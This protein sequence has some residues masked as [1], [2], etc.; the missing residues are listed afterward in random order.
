MQENIRELEKTVNNSKVNP[1]WLKKVF[2]I[3]NLTNSGER[4]ETKTWR[5][6]E[7]WQ[8]TG[9]ES[10]TEKEK[11]D[12]KHKP[13]PSMAL[14]KS[15]RLFFFSSHTTLRERERERELLNEDVWR[16][17]MRSSS[18]STATRTRQLS[19]IR[20]SDADVLTRVLSFW[21]VSYEDLFGSAWQPPLRASTGA[22]YRNKT[23][24]IN[25]CCAESEVPPPAFINDRNI[26]PEPETATLPLLELTLFIVWWPKVYGRLAITPLP[27]TLV[28]HPV[29]PVHD[30]VCIF[31]EGFVPHIVGVSVFVHL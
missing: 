18:D 27:Y 30:L 31:S 2:G 24:V 22:I 4:K 3:I 26:H 10:E 9:W 13:Q 5:I 17:Q 11:A 21:L 12:E 14:D 29:H 8:Q 19:S 1:T 28:K 16:D 25:W 6:P 20:L 15:K 23:L 7:A